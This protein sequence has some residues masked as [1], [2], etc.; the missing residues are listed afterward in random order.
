MKGLG[1]WTPLG[2]KNGVI[3]FIQKKRVTVEL[4]PRT[5]APTKL[6]TFY[7]DTLG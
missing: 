4:Q 3:L 7:D 1:G 6:K 2:E 5:I